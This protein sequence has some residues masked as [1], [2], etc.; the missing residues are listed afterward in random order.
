MAFDRMKSLENY[1][2]SCSQLPDFQ[3]IL[4]TQAA[5]LVKEIRQLNR[6]DFDEGAPL[7]AMVQQNQ[8]WTQELKAGIV[9]AIQSKVSES[10]GLRSDRVSFQ[11]LKHFPCYLTAK[12]WEIIFNVE[13]ALYVRVH[14]VV[15]RLW[16]LGLMNPNEDTH[17]M[18]TVVMVLTDQ[19]KL[20]DVF[21]LRKSYLRVKNLVKMNLSSWTKGKKQNNA[22]CIPGLA[23]NCGNLRG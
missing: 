15:E 8:H 23:T 3:E 9:Q 17:A 13:K 2:Q 6:L 22:E 21:E 4:R 7:L 14:C 20:T 19:N 10:V 1:L 18:V 11:D 16:R 12:D 5:S